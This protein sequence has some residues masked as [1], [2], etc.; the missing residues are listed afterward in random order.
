M[1]PRSYSHLIFVP[2]TRRTGHVL[3]LGARTYG[4]TSSAGQDRETVRAHKAHGTQNGGKNEYIRKSRAIS[5]ARLWRRRLYTCL[6]STSSSRT[7]LSG[8]LISRPASHLDAFSAYPFQTRIPGGAPG[9]T[10]GIPE[11]CPARSSRTSARSTQDSCAHD[12]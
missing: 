1:G 7:T 5:K 6:L 8:V 2:S 4:K 11:V 10:T 9:G 12:R 3:S